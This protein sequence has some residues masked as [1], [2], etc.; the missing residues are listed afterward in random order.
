MSQR[1]ATFLF[2]CFI[3]ISSSIRLRCI[4]FD[5]SRYRGLTAT[6]LVRTTRFIMENC[7]LAQK[8]TPCD[9]KS[10]G[11]GFLRFTYTAKRRHLLLFWFLQQ[12]CHAFQADAQRGHV[13]Q[14][15]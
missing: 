4:V 9:F 10:Q 14:H 7:L 5:G 8:P 2:N 12:I 13:V 1:M 6:N 3:N 11:V 15:G